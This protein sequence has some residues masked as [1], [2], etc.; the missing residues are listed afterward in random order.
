MPTARPGISAMWALGSLGD[1]S[2][3]RTLAADVRIADAGVR[4]MTVYALGAL[5]GEAQ[6]RVRSAAA[7]NDP[8]P[9]VQ[10]N[11]AVALARHQNDEGVASAR[12]DA[13]SRVCERAC[14]A[15][16]PM[17]IRIDPVGE[18]MIEARLGRLPC[19]A[20]TSFVSQ[21]TSLS[22]AD[23][24]LRVRQVAMETLKALDE[25]PDGPDDRRRT[26]TRGLGKAR[27]N[28]RSAA[29]SGEPRATCT[30]RS[31]R[32]T[33]DTGCGRSEA[34]GAHRQAR[35]CSARTLQGRPRRRS[36]STSRPAAAGQAGGGCG[37]YLTAPDAPRVARRCL[38]LV[39]RGVSRRARGN[40]PVHV[41][42][43]AQRAAAAVQ[44]RI[45]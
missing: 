23:P 36:A 37:R 1:P 15:R 28:R 32:Q 9:D 30:D 42:Q 4:K 34:G 29:E 27:L 26:D 38:G 25:R 31:A 8:V 7:L 21:V 17:R 43:R 6:R 2:V 18:V 45:S 44:G 39:F 22:R 20:T 13:R 35:A 14:T 12:A 40:R 16:V 41:S 11:A 10:W 24:S 5:P 33:G 3:S 19:F